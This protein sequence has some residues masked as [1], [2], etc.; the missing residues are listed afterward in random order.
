MTL[1]NVNLR[2]D[3]LNDFFAINDLPLTL[4]AGF[5]N[6]L[7]LTVKTQYCFLSDFPLSVV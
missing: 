3:E 4:K 7:T 1:K 2:P 5:A 6:K